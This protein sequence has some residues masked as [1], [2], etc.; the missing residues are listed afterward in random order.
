V[1]KIT[2]FT[3]SC[4]VLAACFFWQSGHAQVD[5]VDR[6]L[7]ADANHSDVVSDTG[8]ASVPTSSNLAELYYQVQVL[9]N[10][11]QQ[12][13]GITEEQAHELKGLKRQRLDDYIDLD[14]RIANLAQ[15]GATGNETANTGKPSNQA[16]DRNLGNGASVSGKPRSTSS[17]GN[18]LTNYRAAM[19]LV[20]KEKKYD[21]AIPALKQH[22][23]DFPSGRYAGNSQ[24][25]LG[26][27]HLLQGNIE[28]ARESFAVLLSQYPGHSKVPD[29]KYKLGTTYDLLGDKVQ[30]KTLLEEVASTSSNAAKLA[31]AYLAKHFTQ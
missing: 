29:A 21:E 24:Y 11:V 4:G 6:E 25:W 19:Q 13:R 27:I 9:Q 23:T 15:P 10:E 12:L 8:D 1:L 5:V 20:L 3:K 31:K 22:I 17:S 26:E 16:N 2:T 14:R 18:E 28:L 30:A 7:P